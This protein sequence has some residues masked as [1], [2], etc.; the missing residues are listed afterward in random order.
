MTI[1]PNLPYNDLPFLPPK[2]DFEKKDILNTAIRANRELA[3]YAWDLCDF[4]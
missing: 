2:I 3:K 1:Y 4:K